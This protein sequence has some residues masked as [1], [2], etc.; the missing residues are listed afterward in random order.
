MNLKKQ[1]INSRD[2]VMIK[3]RMVGFSSQDPLEAIVRA[4]PLG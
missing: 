1:G 2:W 3:K 4:G